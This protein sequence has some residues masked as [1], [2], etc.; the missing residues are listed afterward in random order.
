MSIK[1]DSQGEI[2]PEDSVES[3][4]TPIKVN[5]YNG[6]ETPGLASALSTKLDAG[7]ENIIIEIVNIGNAKNPY[8]KTLVVNNKVIAPEIIE[9]IATAIDAAVADLPVGEDTADADV[10]IFIGKDYTE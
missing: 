9:K 6:T 2:K 10:L 7:I 8:E 5:I 1:L 4:I 3:V